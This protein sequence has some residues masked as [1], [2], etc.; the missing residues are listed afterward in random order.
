MPRE[1]E[2]IGGLPDSW[3]SA[4]Q[5]IIIYQ[6]PPPET[7]SSTSNALGVLFWLA[8]ITL[9]LAV[10]GFCAWAMWNPGH[11]EDRFSPIYAEGRPL[12]LNK[13]IEERTQVNQ[14]AAGLLE[15]RERVRT[16]RELEAPHALISGA[17]DSID[18]LRLQWDQSCRRIRRQIY[19]RRITAIENDVL[20]VRRQLA[21]ASTTEER[22]A[23]TEE[24]NRLQD[25]QRR[26]VRLR[27]ADSDPQFNCIRAAEAD[28]CTT[29]DHEP[30]C[31]GGDEVFNR[32][33]R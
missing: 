31:D 22:A 11:D 21:V 15:Y 16:R 23:L 9:C 2:T 29:A 14:A 6:G 3:R 30:W 20:R 32:R 26:H 13:L 8:L 19:E 5:P 28:A 25:E 12:G 24:R 18:T 4:N 17:P 33:R 10:A 27:D 1:D 7:E